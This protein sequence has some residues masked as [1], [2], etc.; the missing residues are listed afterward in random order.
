MKK[1]ILTTSFFMLACFVSNNSAIAG[2]EQTLVAQL[3]SCINKTQA[4][5]S[6]SNER[7]RV[8]VKD[9]FVYIEGDAGGADAQ[10]CIGQYN[11]GAS[12]CPAAPQLV[13]GFS[14]EGGVESFQ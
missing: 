4:A 2:C 10:M 3:R 13:I 6:E 11:S 1:I 14:E 7:M 9:G 5:K 8:V 12:S